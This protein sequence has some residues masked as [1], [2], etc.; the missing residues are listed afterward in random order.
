MSALTACGPSARILIVDDDDQIRLILKRMLE[1]R[2]YECV[3]ATNAGEAR[4]CLETD[5]AGFTLMLCDVN[6]PGESGLELIQHVLAEHPGTA[7]LMVTGLDDPQ[8]ADVALEYGAYGYMTKPFK[9]S[10]LLI[11]V[12]NALRRRALELENRAHRDRLEHTVLERT[13]ALRDAVAR[14][15]ESERDLRLYQEET[16]SRLSS[17]AELRDAETGRHIERMSRTCFLLAGRLGLDPEL[18]E[19]I[20]AASPMHDIGKIAIPDSILLKPGPLTADERKVMERHTE[21]GYQILA[22]SE[23]RLLQLAATLAWTHHEY[24]DGSGYPR[25]LQ[26]DEIPLEGRIAAVADVFDALLT[27]R[28][29][30]SACSIDEAVAMMRAKR[31]RQFDPEILDVFLDALPQVIDLRD[32]TVEITVGA[33]NLVAFPRRPIDA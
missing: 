11:N 30:R 9:A 4:R 22:G 13:A 6:M 21:I 26:G 12:A 32:G 5:E 27:D 19:L 29:Y 3:L 2:G 10:E 31:G 7:A 25:G 18:A 28:P 15:E 1:R 33:T 16:V 24:W 23:A 17:A 8:L 14:L 20:R